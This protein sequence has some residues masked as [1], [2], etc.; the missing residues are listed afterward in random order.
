MLL[1]H[2]YVSLPES[3]CM[4]YRFIYYD[5]DIASK[6]RKKYQHNISTIKME[7][8]QYNDMEIYG[9]SWYSEYVQSKDWNKSIKAHLYSLMLAK[10]WKL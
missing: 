1:R 4:S 5:I 2:N 7:K 3:T 8:Y 10:S 6:N 9:E